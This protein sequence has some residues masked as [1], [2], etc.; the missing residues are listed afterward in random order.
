MLFTLLEPNQ[1]YWNNS[2]ILVCKEI[3]KEPVGSFYLLPGRAAVQQRNAFVDETLVG[4]FVLAEDLLNGRAVFKH[5]HLFLLLQ[6]HLQP[7]LSLQDLLLQRHLQF[8]QAK[9]NQ[10]CAFT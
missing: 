3:A 8:L 7:L 6:R 5:L 4:A 1:E 9:K 2:G 10:E